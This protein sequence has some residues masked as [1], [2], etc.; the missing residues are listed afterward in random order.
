MSSSALQ[1]TGESNNHSLKNGE[2]Y[3]DGINWDDLGFGLIP[4]DYMYTMKCSDGENFSQGHLSPFGKIEL[5]PSAGILNYGQGLFEG[6]KATR[7]ED[8]RIMLFRPQEN[9]LRMK[10]GAERMC[11]PSPS[12][13]QFV[14][15]VKQTVFA[16]KR[17]VPPPGKGSL[18]I[19]PLLMG[20]GSNLGL[21]PGLEYTFLIFAS[22]VGNNYH[23]GRAALNLYVEHKIHRATPGGTGGVKSV[24]NYSPV[25]QTQQQARAKGFSDVLFLDSA[26][27]KNIEEIVAANIFIRK[28]NVISTP[29]LKH[30]TIL[31][32]VTRKSIIDIALDFGY[33]V[34]ERVIPVEDLLA[35][36]EAFCTGTAVVVNPIGAVTY[37]D[38]RVEYKT[39]GALCQKLYETLT[40]IQTGRL[41]DKKGWTLEVN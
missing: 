21:G 40:G 39:G 36:D 16:N 34:E 15:A 1:T 12:V 8:G 22:P 25:Y 35:A 13:E 5:C 20:S 24:T 3:A 14:D 18:Y 29:T 6:L 19:R 28:G 7:T 17:W 30:G 2:M 27:G 37:Q 41:Q 10:M 38:K 23:K 31:P 9:A 32:G 33:Q 11:M 26:T 4:I